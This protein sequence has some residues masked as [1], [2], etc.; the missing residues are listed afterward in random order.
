VKNSRRPELLELFREHVY[1]R[2]PVERP[3]MMS[4]QVLFTRDV[5]DGRATG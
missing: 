3:D 2:N 4:F 1:G 5:F